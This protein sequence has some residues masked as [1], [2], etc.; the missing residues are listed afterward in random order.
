LWSK[1]SEKPTQNQ[2]KIGKKHEKN[3]KNLKNFKKII[4]DKK[5]VGEVEKK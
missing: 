2:Q 5:L 1:N 3:L 4:L